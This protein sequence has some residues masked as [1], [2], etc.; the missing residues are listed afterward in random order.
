MIKVLGLLLSVLLAAGS[1][2]GC[3]NQ[4]NAG[5]VSAEDVSEKVQEAV[6]ED[7]P[8]T[9]AEQASVERIK[10][11][12]DFFNYTMPIGADLKRMIT[13]AAE[14][15]DCDVEFTANDF[16]AETSITNVENL[17]ASGCDS[18]IFCNSADGQIPKALKIAE[19]YDGKI[20]QFFRTISD[21][22]IK[23][24][25]FASPYYGGQV[26]EDEYDVGYNMGKIMSEKGCK[27]VG[28]INFNHGD[29]TAE[30][31]Q[32]GYEAALKELGVNIVASTW[33][34]T[35][36]ETGS[37]TA[38]N[39]LAAYPEMD[40]IALVGGSG[41]AL[42]GV[43]SALKSHKKT[44][45]IV[46]VTTDFYE[47]MGSDIADGTLTAISGGHWCDPFFSFMLA[48]NDAA[49]AF[50]NG[51]VPAEIQMDMIYVTSAQ[52]GTDFNKWFVES[53]PYN[54]KEIKELSIVYN[55]NMNFDMLNKA[56]QSLTLQDV[57]DRHS[58]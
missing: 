56:A 35:T 22:D 10:I 27:N 38:E 39:Y 37:Q 15:L 4:S 21:E 36:S 41:E 46:L 51:E 45:D 55:E 42:Y 52:E 1:L 53:N 23:K 18:V 30:T 48:Y 49:G 3:G 2:T 29:L 12:V 24:A 20:F 34:I 43:Q 54:E 8:V 13:A 17:F 40:G 31:R 44:E 16:D 50:K 57:V 14:A 25:A 9:A 7:T 6:S 5:T 58:K 26:H 32:K 19:Q 11:G 33:E 47:K 28:L